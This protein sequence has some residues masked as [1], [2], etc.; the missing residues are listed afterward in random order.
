MSYSVLDRA[1]LRERLLTN[2]NSSSTLRS[3]RFRGF[4]QRFQHKSS[5]GQG[6]RDTRN[7]AVVG[8][9]LEKMLVQGGRG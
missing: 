4:A 2:L 9:I 5:S 6:A 8:P 3:C 1:R 7:R